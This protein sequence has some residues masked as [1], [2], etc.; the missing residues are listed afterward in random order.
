MARLLELLGVVWLPGLLFAAGLVAVAVW[1]RRR[2]EGVPAWGWLLLGGAGVLAGLGGL[3]TPSAVGFWLTVAAGGLLFAKLVVLVITG[4]WLTPLGAALGGL[5]L[6]GL[7]G[8]LARDAG[9]GIVYFARTLWQSEFAQPWW[10]LLLLLIPVI[11][12]LSYR[13]LAGLGPVRRWV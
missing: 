13:S 3:T 1:T 10:L 6:L 11:V 4:H 8:W 9:I 2:S 7:G 12:W 5:T